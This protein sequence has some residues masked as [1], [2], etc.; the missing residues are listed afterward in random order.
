MPAPPVVRALPKDLEA[1][2]WAISALLRF[3]PR[4]QTP[5]RPKLI[6]LRGG[7]TPVT[8]GRRA[9]ERALPPRT[10][11]PRRFRIS[12]FVLRACLQRAGRILDSAGGVLYTFSGSARPAL[13]E[14]IF[15]ICNALIINYLQ[16]VSSASPKPGTA[17][18]LNLSDSE[19]IRHGP[20]IPNQQ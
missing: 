8:G 20:P 11:R 19:S 16:V 2:S 7:T 18:A 1:V 15:V 3:C 4:P 13:W 5:P 17:S 12:C 10:R 9:L 14:K 6:G